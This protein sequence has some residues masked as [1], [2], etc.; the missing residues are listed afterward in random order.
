[1]SLPCGAILLVIL[2]LAVSYHFKKEKQKVEIS[3]EWARLDPLPDSASIISRQATGSMFTR[4]FDV[5]FKAPL[6]E[7]KSWLDLSPGTSGIAPVFESG[8]DDDE[9]LGDNVGSAGLGASGVWR[10]DIVPG[11]GAQFAAVWVDVDT[12]TVRIR[13]YWS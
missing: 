3:R 9:V 1:M 11:G 7:I 2:V 6:P 5:K 8:G 12:G 13:T 10:Y 4:G